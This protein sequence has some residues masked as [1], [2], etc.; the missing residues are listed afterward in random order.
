MHNFKRFILR[1]I[2]QNC[3]KNTRK[4]RMDQHVQFF[5][6]NPAV[7]DML[8]VQKFVH[9]VCVL[10]FPFD[11]P[12]GKIDIRCAIRAAQKE[13]ELIKMRVNDAD[14]CFYRL[15]RNESTHPQPFHI[16]LGYY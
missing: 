3:F 10:Q 11:K 12:V 9:T 14:K 13:F 8:F 5:S 15:C 7:F 4:V 6:I 1:V 16:Y 2:M